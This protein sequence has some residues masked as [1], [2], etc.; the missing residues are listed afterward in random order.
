MIGSTSFLSGTLAESGGRCC[1]WPVVLIVLCAAPA[2][3]AAETSDSKGVVVAD[4]EDPF[5]PLATEIA[6]DTGYAL[7]D[8]PAAALQT[9]P[10]F[11]I[12]VVSPSAVSERD[13]VAYGQATK[14]RASIV[15]M[16][17]ITGGTLQEARALWERRRGADNRSVAVIKGRSYDPAAPG[18]RIVTW[19]EGRRTSRPL[20]VHAA[21]QVL[22]QSDYVTF[23]GHGSPTA[24]FFEDAGALRADDV[25]QLPP[26]VIVT[27][28]CSTLQFWHDKSIALSFVDQGTAAY[29]GFVFDPNAGYL[30]GAYEGMAFRYTWPDFPVGHVVQVLNRGC[31]QGFA[32]FPQYYVIGDPRM[33]LADQPPYEIVEDATSGD[34]R[35]IV[36][37]G[38]PAGV[39]PIRV[40]N[41]AHYRYVQ[42][43]GVTAAS[44]DDWFYNS[45]LQMADL[46]D[47]KLILL[48]QSGGDFVV[49]L[50]PRASALWMA[51][52]AVTD[53]L[54]HNLICATSSGAQL[55]LGSIA[56][57]VL[58]WKYRKSGWRTLTSAALTG[59]AF[60]L[61]LGIYATLRAD[62]VTITSKPIEFDWLTLLGCFLLVTSGCLLY[63]N[64]RRWWGEVVGLL[65]ATVPQWF[66]A[67]GTALFLFF[68][69]TSASQRVGSALW[70]YQLAFV[71][72]AAFL[73]L[74]PFMWIWFQ[75]LRRCVVRR[76]HP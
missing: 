12:W 3:M 53:S 23:S 20:T 71:N 4:R 59:L 28:N 45:R 75:V 6:D 32:A 66:A 13:F 50:R 52:D 58:G 33:A 10:T 69:A 17:I 25:P 11:V 72:L 47:D 16:G 61:L 76:C 38:A 67:L 60:A 44:A 19:P 1:A 74:A 55:I 64:A 56:L 31:G 36:V 5:R 7:V 68:L 30:L 49:E 39:I 73:V 18:G 46:N 51:A 43:A 35:R 41:G 8:S 29:A 34:Q 70:N 22:Q 2:V 57:V 48:L 14:D 9:N 26:I 40:P 42:V 21:Q 27:S 24:L 15:S 54:D 65:I 62:D 37:R 63:L